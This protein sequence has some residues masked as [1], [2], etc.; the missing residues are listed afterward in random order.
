[1]TYDLEALHVLN[2]VASMTCKKIV[3]FIVFTN[4]VEAELA[5]IWLL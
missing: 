5:K 2:F 4:M 1:M 3:Y